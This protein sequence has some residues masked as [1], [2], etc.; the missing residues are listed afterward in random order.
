MTS[1][2]RLLLDADE[3]AE[4]LGVTRRHLYALTRDHG[5]PHVRI[6]RYLKFRREALE[7]WVEEQEVGATR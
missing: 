6:G 5:L 2:G 1:N 7:R 3:A 4:L